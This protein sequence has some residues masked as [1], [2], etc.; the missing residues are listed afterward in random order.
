MATDTLNKNDVNC[1]SLYN[2][3]TAMERRC[4][5]IQDC[6]DK[7]VA[8]LEKGDNS[9][10]K[11]KVF[12]HHQIPLLCFISD[13]E[14][15]RKDFTV[16]EILGSGNFGAVYKGEAT[17]LF[18]PGSKTPVAMKTINDVTNHNDTDCFLVE[19]KILSDIK[20][21]CNLVNMVGTYTTSIRETGEVWML[22]EYCELGD[23]KHFVT[24]NRN[25]FQNTFEDRVDSNP[26]I[27]SRLL[28][29]WSYD[30][31]KGME[32]LATKFVMHGDLSARNILL[33]WSGNSN[34]KMVAKVADF[35]LSK[36]MTQKISYEKKERNYVP[37][38]WM[39]F[40][41]LES[42]IF[43]MKS[44]VWSY[45]V[46]IWEIFSLGEHPY[47]DKD[48]DEVFEDLQIGYRL[49]CPDRIQNIKNWPAALFYN[50]IA[51]KCFVLE[52]NDRSSFEDIISFI[53]PMLNEAELKSYEQVS[54]QRSFRYN[55]ILD[56]QSRGRIRTKSTSTRKITLG[57][58]QP[59]IEVNDRRPSCL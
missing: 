2:E 32:Y 25:S 4:Q 58:G 3:E 23:L 45:G 53:Q 34:K 28:L 33:T 19:I 8:S 55:L 9:K 13:R 11:D 43:K 26:N 24:N 56:E 31:A 30:I 12:L 6:L 29:H 35:G 48:F 57:V 18:Y 41:F 17:G 1:P 49:Q 46:V 51:E 36:K 27:E 40:E 21:H 44:D 59:C 15:E 37:W 10:I 47:G 52:E 7:F 16:G 39:A 14:V 38:K 50:S 5:S 42:N 20:Y 22:L 54:N